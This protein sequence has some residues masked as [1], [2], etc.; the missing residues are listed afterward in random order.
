MA[1]Q[2]HTLSSFDE[3]LNETYGEIGNPERDEFEKESEIFM[4]AELLKNARKKAG[5]TQE[6]LANRI[7]TKKAYISKVEKGKADI[8]LSTFL[9]IV[10]QGMNKQVSLEI[11]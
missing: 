2:S 4:V 11:F 3:Y 7:G 5:L 8:Q 6:E 1:T 9:R 10:K